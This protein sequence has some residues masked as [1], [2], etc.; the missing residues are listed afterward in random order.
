[1]NIYSARYTLRSLFRDC[2]RG[3]LARR[4]LYPQLRLNEFSLSALQNYQTRIFSGLN[5]IDE[6]NPNT[7]AL[8]DTDEHTISKDIVRRSPHL[9]TRKRTF[10]TIIRNSI[11]TS[12]SSGR[13][14]TLVQDL[15]AIT[16][17][18]AFVYR[19]LRWTG[20]TYGDRRAW[21]RGD[22]V[23]GDNPTKGMYG[24]MDFWSN[25]L[26]LSSY[27][28]SPETALSYINALSGFNPIIIQ[29]YP[30]S[31]HA[32]A[33]W[34]LSN[35]FQYEGEA[36]RGIITSSET[37]ESDMRARIEQ[38]FRCRVFDWYGQAERVAAIGTCE[39]GGRHVL[40]D[41][42]RVELLPA[43]DGL[44]ELVGTGYNNKA[45]PLTR[46]R[47]GDF[48]RLSS[49]QSCPCGR[50]F[51]IVDQVIGR[52]DKVITLPDGRTIGRLDHV[53]KG[54][55]NVIEGQVIYKG[56][57]HFLLRVV[58][59]PNW[60]QNDVS[61]LVAKLKERVAGVEAHVETVASIPR[62]ANGKFEFVRIEVGG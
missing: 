5:T 32:L 21:L 53:F 27:H 37:L 10:W 16:R 12:G 6:S 48:I 7:I 60:S 22:I 52:R 24:C 49:S 58:P 41:Y 51:P 11:S 9:F 26:M 14:L 35:N 1:M 40:T 57:G 62:G 34:M 55:D 17:E 15:G 44:Y 29:A 59:G 2:V 36:L 25:T 8:L 39:H 4:C 19:Q 54:A 30:S 47:T 43:E 46:Y 28:I 45:M 13:P 56:A 31:I 61:R 18:E 42:G 3:W 20:Y 33:S 23:C 38:A 50:V